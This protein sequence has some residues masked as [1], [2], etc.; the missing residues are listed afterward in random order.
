MLITTS[1][2]RTRAATHPVGKVLTRA[3]RLTVQVHSSLKALRF[4]A[5]TMAH[6]VRCLFCD[7]DPDYE[8]PYEGWYWESSNDLDGFPFRGVMATYGGGG[9][10]IELGINC[11]S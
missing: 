11:Q 5:A 1:S 10:N 2:L 9:F 4:L 8:G 3:V 7:T 6:T